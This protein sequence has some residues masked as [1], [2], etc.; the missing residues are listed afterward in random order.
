ML[1]GLGAP[2]VDV[3]RDLTIAAGREVARRDRIIGM[4]VSQAE[5]V[6]RGDACNLEVDTS[7]ME[8]LDCARAIAARM[9][10]LT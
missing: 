3:R 5:A 8:A 2:W 1:E 9:A 4:A 7:Q 6:H 10:R